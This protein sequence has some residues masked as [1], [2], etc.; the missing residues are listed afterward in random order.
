M[1]TCDTARHTRAAPLAPWDHALHA[2]N[3]SSLVA[4]GMRSTQENLQGPNVILGPNAHLAHLQALFGLAE[5]CPA[6]R[7]RQWLASCS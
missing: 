6:T 3:I 4:C 7:H 2:C 5:V 1:T